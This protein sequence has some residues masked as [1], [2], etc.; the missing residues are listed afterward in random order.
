MQGVFV[1]IAWEG[2]FSGGF[3]GS[4]DFYCAKARLV[5]ELDGHSHV[6]ETGRRHDAKRTAYLESQGMKVIRF[7]DVDVD[8]NFV[9]FASMQDLRG[10]Q[11]V[12]GKFDKNDFI[13]LIEWDFVVIMKEKGSQITLTPQ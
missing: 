7:F 8:R 5:V 1:E 12:G 6:T 3:S 10:S 13:F 2:E 11:A 9:Y 4:V